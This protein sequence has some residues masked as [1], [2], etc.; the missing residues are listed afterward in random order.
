MVLVNRPSEK[1]KSNKIR[2]AIS[3]IES[4][5]RIIPMSKH[6]ASDQEDLGIKDSKNLWELLLVFLREIEDLE[7]R[8]CYVGGRPPK[9]SYELEVAGKELWAY[10]WQSI[11][12]NKKMYIKFCLVGGY[13]FYV[14]CHK[15]NLKG[16]TR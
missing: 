11:S 15:D 1:E 7:P 5:K 2:E 8:R 12:M 9:K 4:G 13:Y 3:A 10:S 14:G 6:F 16:A